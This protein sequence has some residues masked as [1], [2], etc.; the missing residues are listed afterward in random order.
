MSMDVFPNGLDSERGMYMG[1]YVAILRGEFD[2]QLHWTFDGS[3]TVQA[4]NRT[5][6]QWSK[7]R[8][9][10]LNQ[11]AS[12]VEKVKRCVNQLGLVSWGFPKFLSQSQLKT[13]YLKDTDMVRFRVT[14]V[15]VK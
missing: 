15:V 3:V 13:D 6:Q 10:V 4:Y 9:I 11:N 7:E 5:I 12:G 14:K 8:T 1:V 2:D